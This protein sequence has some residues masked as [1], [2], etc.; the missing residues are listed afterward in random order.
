MSN[1]PFVGKVIERAAISQLQDYISANDLH[2]ENQSA[3]RRF[4]SV[5]TAM[6]RVTNDL[7]RAVDEHGEAALVLLDLS[8]AFDTVD[9]QILLK[10]LST[11]YGV[12]GTAH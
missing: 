4:H 8:A 7:L 11:R 12:T 10:R 9:H 5:E 2:S 3:Y 1:L 6:V